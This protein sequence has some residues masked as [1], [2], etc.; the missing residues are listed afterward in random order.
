MSGHGGKLHSQSAIFTVQF[1]TT[2]TTDWTDTAECSALGHAPC[3][4]PLGLTSFADGG[5][6][7]LLEHAAH[8]P[9]GRAQVARKLQGCVK[10][11]RWWYTSIAVREESFMRTSMV[12]M[13]STALLSLASWLS[14]QPAEGQQEFG[15]ETSEGIEA[16][17]PARKRPVLELYAVVRVDGELRVMKRSEAIT[18]RIRA[19]DDFKTALK[20]YYKAKREATKKGDKY[21]VP[22]P[23]MPRVSTLRSTFKSLQAAEAYRDTILKRL[24]E[25]EA[26]KTTGG[27]AQD[28]QRKP[29]EAPPTSRPPAPGVAKDK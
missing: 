4:R 23:T 12:A 9:A 2:L 17:A 22:R 28:P 29:D 24:R 7:G 27:V 11:R 15:R 10:E 14:A 16:E 5:R 8:Q 20:E 21:D 13:A 1:L 19:S 26:S 18:L 6:C 25:R 3:N